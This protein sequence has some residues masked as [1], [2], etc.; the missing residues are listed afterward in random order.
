M[1]QAK[2]IFILS[3]CL[4]FGI[5]EIEAQQMQDALLITSQTLDKDARATTTRTYLTNDKVLM[6]AE[7]SEMP[8]ILFDAK[9]EELYLIDHKKKEYLSMTKQEMEAMHNSLKFASAEVQKQLEALPEGERKAVEEQMRK[10]MQKHKAA[11]IK[12]TRHGSEIPIKEWKGWKYEGR[13]GKRLRNDVYVVSY[14][15]LERDKEDFAALLALHAFMQEYLEELSK[16]MPALFG[17]FYG[18]EAGGEEYFP[19]R[20]VHYNEKGKPTFTSSIETIEEASL[21]EE[22]WLLPDK[23]KQKKFV[24]SME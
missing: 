4:L 16:S 21:K 6:E 8:V 23:Y 7:D 20:N 22:K 24:A 10:Q 14:K 3:L 19:L 2:N 18:R 9:K 17:H 11:P 13:E 15:A 5:T 1:K 12:Y